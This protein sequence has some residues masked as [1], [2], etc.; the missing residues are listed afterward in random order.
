[1]S[2]IRDFVNKTRKEKES[3]IF[4]DRCKTKFLTSFDIKPCFRV[5]NEID[6]SHKDSKSVLKCGDGK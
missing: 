2:E 5:I 3:D 4:R 6:I 1:M